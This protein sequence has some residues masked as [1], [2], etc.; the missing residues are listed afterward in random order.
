M[1]VDKI[2][3][4]LNTLKS[5]SE[6]V[7]LVPSTNIYVGWRRTISTF[8]SVVLTIVGGSSSG[9]LGYLNTKEREDTITIQIDIHSTKSQYEAGLIADRIEKIL[10]KCPGDILTAE[11][12]GDAQFFDEDFEVWRRSIRFD[13]RYIYVES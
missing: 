10:L 1:T 13:L 9:R 12:V 3:S 5:D 2:T 6:L 11:K 8:P 4:L 7:N